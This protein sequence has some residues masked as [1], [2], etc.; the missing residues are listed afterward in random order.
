MCGQG[1]KLLTERIIHTAIQIQAHEIMAHILS[2]VTTI[3]NFLLCTSQNKEN[4]PS[5]NATT[6][7]FQFQIFT[8]CHISIKTVAPIE[9]TCSI[10][11]EIINDLMKLFQYNSFTT[12]SLEQFVAVKDRIQG[13]SRLGTC[14]AENQSFLY[15]S[16]TSCHVQ[17][18]VPDQGT[19]WSLDIATLWLRG[20]SDWPNHFVFVES[21]DRENP[22]RMSYY[23][24]SL[25]I[26][27]ARGL[28]IALDIFNKTTR[29]IKLPFS[30]KY[31]E[32]AQDEI[33]EDLQLNRFANP[34][35]AYMQLMAP[36]LSNLHM[37][38]VLSGTTIST[39][40]C[41]I[42]S[43]NRPSECGTPFTRC[44]PHLLSSKFNY[45][46]TF[47][48]SFDY[49]QVIFTSQGAFDI[50][51]INL[52]AYFARAKWEEWIPFGTFSKHIQFQAFQ[53]RPTFSA[54]P[55]WKPYNR[56]TWT[57]SL[58]AKLGLFVI[59]VIYLKKRGPSDII[60]MMV[61]LIS[62]ALDQ[63]TTGQWQLSIR[64]KT[65][66][67]EMLAAVW[68]MWV[69]LLMILVNGYKGAICA[70]LITGMQPEWPGS[71]VE[72][73]NDADYRILT[74]EPNQLVE[75]QTTV[76]RRSY[77]RQLYL[78]PTINHNTMHKMQYLKLNKTLM[79]YDAMDSDVIT[80]MVID[81]LKA[82]DGG[83]ETSFSIAGTRC[84]KLALID[85]DPER[86][87]V[88]M[89]YLMEDVLMSEQIQLPGFRVV[90]TP[91]V[92]RNF[93]T[94]PYIRGIAALEQSGI[95]RA[96]EKHV[97]RLKTCLSLGGRGAMLELLH[98]KIFRMDLLMQRCLAQISGSNI[99]PNEL[100]EIPY[101]AAI[102]FHQ[103]AFI[104]RILLFG[105]T[106]SCSMLLLEKIF[107]AVL[108]FAC[109]NT[110]LSRIAT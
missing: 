44:L 57:L 62:S 9:S 64:L 56:I 33:F 102:S 30:W 15:L 21:L 4:A 67:P 109:T 14:R 39:Q 75:N 106:L 48:E 101:P 22:R 63:P 92:S 76:L 100:K 13:K 18:H 95:L 8:G 6:F 86:D 94:E 77:V 60:S 53:G 104:V 25:P 7:D 90:T 61:S 2:L 55:L 1:A 89:L 96:L 66:R 50:G 49:N 81:N 91:Y 97:S 35:E 69:F 34:S 70:Y 99:Y 32:H 23:Y 82:V 93:F 43:Q 83:V 107:L 59:S 51:D 47:E 28:I 105:V 20:N 78:I 11:I 27:F 36:H 52:D 85:P 29:L 84:E 74:S 16:K 31:G 38:Q 40:F 68:L 37:L 58:L 80:D 72:L 45:T 71:L 54:K 19:F 98:P 24:N 110:W 108:E 87:A 42:M 3:V 88:S 103:L 79:Y 73:V 12:F 17:M 5:S 26:S 10:H 41:N 65:C 46:P